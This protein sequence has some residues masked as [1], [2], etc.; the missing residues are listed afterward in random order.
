MSTR[1]VA[2]SFTELCKAGKFEEA[3]Q[4]FWHENIVSL[5]PMTGEMAR[6]QGRKAVE[7]K[8]KWWAD[9]HQVHAVK[10]EGPFLHGDEFTVRFEMDVTPKGKSRMT[11]REI[12]LYKVKDGKVVEERFYASE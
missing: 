2:K 8:S 4:K 10:V 9:N 7:G 12:A 1:D 11:M 3:G 5:E 6:L